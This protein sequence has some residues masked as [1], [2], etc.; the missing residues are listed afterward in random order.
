MIITSNYHTHSTFCDGK[1][2][3]E[4]MVLEAIKKG[5][6]HLGFS[7]HSYLEF[8]SSYCMKPSA[9]P[10]YRKTVNELKEKY[11][12]EIKIFCGIEQ[13]YYAEK[14]EGYDYILGS[15]HYVFKNGKHLCIDHSANMLKS[16][17]DNEY[18]GD[19]DALA[20]DYFEVVSDIINKTNCD[21]IGHFDLISKY[22]EILGYGESEKFLYAAEKA[23]KKL[24][25]FGC[26]FEINT[27]AI[28]RK[29]RTIPYPSP[30]ILK[31]IKSYDGKITFSSDCHDKNYL[32]CYFNEIYKMAVDLGFKEY[33]IITENGIEYVNL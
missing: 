33:A 25:P 13:D 3:P 8:D 20:E 26:P 23:I 30:E 31:I 22:S 28:P 32:D 12:N 4:E 17:I 7:G 19:F 9:E 10:I 1:D 11:K 24:V 16:H 15:V 6:T 2:T 21:I 27:G 18:S 5:F 29:A 14:A